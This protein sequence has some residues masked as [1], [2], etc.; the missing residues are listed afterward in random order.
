MNSSAASF[1][2]PS[3]ALAHSSKH[4]R[5]GH[6]GAIAADRLERPTS[7]AVGPVQSRALHG[8][9]KTGVRRG[10][11]PIQSEESAIYGAGSS[12]QA[13]QQL[14]ASAA[15]LGGFRDVLDTSQ[16]APSQGSV[17]GILTVLNQYRHQGGGPQAS[18]TTEKAWIHP[19]DVTALYATDDSR[20]F[21]KNQGQ[22]QGP[23][24]GYPSRAGTLKAGRNSAGRASASQFGTAG[25]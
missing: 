12:T 18:S 20:R 7:A 8:R 13:P 22:L 6:K 2:T 17:E 23:G 11:A 4:G 15:H 3:L 16:D 10:G 21:A 9:P 24:Q 25:G 19:M 5:K 14:H 1:S